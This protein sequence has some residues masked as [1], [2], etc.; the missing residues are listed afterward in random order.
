MWIG[1]V[2]VSTV[3]GLLASYDLPLTDKALQNRDRTVIEAGAL[4]DAVR[5]ILAASDDPQVIDRFATHV[6]G[7]GKLRE[8]EQFF[9]QVTLPRIR[10]AWRAWGREHLPA[11][12]YYVASGNQ[13][14]VLGLVD[15]GYTEVAA[16]G[17]GDYQQRVLMDLLGVEVARTK[18]THHYERTRGKT[19]WVP[20]RALTAAEQT[21]LSAARQLIH[22]TIGPFTLDRVRVYSSSEQEPCAQGFYTPGTGDVAIHRDALT[23]RHQTLGTLVHEAAHRVGHRGGGRWVPIHDYHDRSRGFER[24]LTEFAALLL[25]HLADGASLPDLAEQPDPAPQKRLRASAADDPAVPAVR[26]E[27]AHLLTDRLPH[28]LTAG[29]FT[30]EKDLVASTGVTPGYLNLLSG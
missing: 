18:L 27:L 8:P 24:L 2:L 30:S 19:T 16:R 3:P 4:R 5:T 26:R 12:T 28:A 1:G 23:D 13:E 9:T 21:T 6:L 29:R 10:A 22:R 15:R 7:G 25:G 17:L 14:A 11:Q 20:E